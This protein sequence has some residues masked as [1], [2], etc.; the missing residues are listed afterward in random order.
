MDKAHWAT[1]SVAVLSVPA[2]CIIDGSLISA[3]GGIKVVLPRHRS[4]FLL[5]LQACAGA[6][7]GLRY[8]GPRETTG[9]ARSGRGGTGAG[10]RGYRRAPARTPGASSD[11]WR[12]LR[13]TCWGPNLTLSSRANPGNAAGL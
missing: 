5:P 7:R 9:A 4:T 10:F 8:A 2:A 13:V 12:T 11:G 6:R 1:K 3:R